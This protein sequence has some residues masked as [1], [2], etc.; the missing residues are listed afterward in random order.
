M[1]REKTKEW[2]Q[3]YSNIILETMKPLDTYKRWKLQLLKNVRLIDEF[4]NI[5]YIVYSKRDHI[6]TECPGAH[7]TTTKIDRFNTI[8][9]RYNDNDNDNDA[10]APATIFSILRFFN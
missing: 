7:A 6:I 4:S 1:L 10:Y 3:Q 5:P 9:V 2:P 8:E